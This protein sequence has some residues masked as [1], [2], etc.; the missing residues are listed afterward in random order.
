MATE[1]RYEYNIV[2]VQVMVM[3]TVTVTVMVTV[4][5]D[6]SKMSSPIFYLFLSSNATVDAP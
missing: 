2:T 1:I 3:V 4:M 6:G 5:G